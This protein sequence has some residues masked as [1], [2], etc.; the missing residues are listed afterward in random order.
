MYRQYIPGE[1]LYMDVGHAM[2]D[3]T[4]A[5]LKDDAVPGSIQDY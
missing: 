2:L 5:A 1:Q 4:H 3:S